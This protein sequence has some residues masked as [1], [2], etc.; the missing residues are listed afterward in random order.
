MLR[1]T[2]SV[3]T[4]SFLMTTAGQAQTMADA[5]SVLK[6][7]SKAAKTGA[8]S[9]PNFTKEEATD[10][11][12]LALNKSADVVVSQLGKAGGFANDPKVRIGLPGP[13]AKVSG[14]LEVLDSVGVTKGL[15]GKLN[16]AAEGAVGKAGPLL[17][18]SIT[19]MSV[20]DAIGI[21]TGGETSATDYFKRTMGVS[22]KTE[23]TP[24]VSDSLKGVDAYTS[25]NNLITK[26]KLPV[27]KFGAND[28]TK[29]VTDKASDGVFY[30][31]GEQEKA[32]RANPLGFGSSLIAK[33]FGK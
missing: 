13:L 8:T 25:L 15:A 26:S 12:K 28:L 2:L 31:L 10:G 33:V 18:K 20:S 22:L 7:I 32:I 19:S 6:K 27:K 30:Y 9:A 16:S 23:M 4:F 3:L 11:L 24:V 14:V 1:R 29:Y 5:S 21:V 17:K